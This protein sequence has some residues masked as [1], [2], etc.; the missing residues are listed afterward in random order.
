MYFDTFFAG[1]G[2][3]GILL[4]GQLL[5][6][7]A[8]NLGF[9]VTWVPQYGVEKRGGD[10]TVMLVIS[11]KEIYSPVVAHPMSMI[12]MH[13]K[14]VSRFVP[15]IKEDGLLLVN[16][17]LIPKETIKRKDIRIV[18]VPATEISI[19]IGNDKIANLIMLGALLKYSKIVP[20]DAVKKIV[21]NE[22]KKGPEYVKLNLLAL[23]EG[24]N[25][26]TSFLQ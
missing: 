14:M 21:T 4:M 5:A 26:N 11:D 24:Y 16:S 9:S 3:Q 23:E 1:I 10:V 15:R 2:G 20:L 8:L 18:E 13:A 22:S 6:R 25:L 17:T 19:E 7:A 12:L